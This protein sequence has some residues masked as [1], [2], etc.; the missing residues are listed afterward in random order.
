MLVRLRKDLVQDSPEFEDGKTYEVFSV[1]EYTA[2]ETE[3]PSLAISVL[4][5]TKGGWSWYPLDEFE[6]VNPE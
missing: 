1:R 4:L 2:Y 6:G 3:Q 5:Y